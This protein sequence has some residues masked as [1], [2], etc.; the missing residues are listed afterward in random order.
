M[1]TWN[2]GMHFFTP[3]YSI[4]HFH[5]LKDCSWDLWSWKT[6]DSLPRP[7][8]TNSFS[9][10]P[11]AATE[12]L[13]MSQSPLWY[14]QT[15]W[16][17][18]WALLIEPW[19]VCFFVDN[20]SPVF[21]SNFICEPSIISLQPSAPFIYTLL[22]AFMGNGLVQ[23]EAVNALE[24]GD[25]SLFS[26]GSCFLL[27]SRFWIHVGGWSQR[28][29][30]H[31]LNSLYLPFQPSTC[32]ASWSITVP[33][34]ASIPPARTSAG[35]SKGTSSTRIRRLAEVRSLCWYV[36]TVLLCS[37]KGL[38]NASVAPPPTSH[39]LPKERKEAL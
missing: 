32:A 30:H 14:Q 10:N 15:F 20:F 11:T 2:L 39:H 18:N 5:I 12:N 28:R 27:H 29:Y 9:S 34:S 22:M 33:T 25:N 1:E 36:C 37:L 3:Q 21:I 26:S 13:H 19:N 24:G 7:H 4:W 31:R 17:P 6:V 35:A 16:F 38:L 8:L 23:P